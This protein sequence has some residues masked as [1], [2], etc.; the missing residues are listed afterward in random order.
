[1]SVVPHAFPPRFRV[2]LP[3]QAQTN[4]APLP[5]QRVLVVTARF[6]GDQIGARGYQ[7]VLLGQLLAARVVVHETREH[8]RR[9]DFLRGLHFRVGQHVYEIHVAVVFDKL[10][11]ARLVHGKDFRPDECE[12]RTQLFGLCGQQLEHVGEYAHGESGRDCP[13]SEVEE[14]AFKNQKIG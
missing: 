10:G 9:V 7:V 13:R 12:K 14:F 11:L 3:A 1:M 5:Q 8:E 6:G 2:V 4:A